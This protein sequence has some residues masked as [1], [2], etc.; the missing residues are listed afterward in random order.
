LAMGVQQA[1][2]DSPLFKGAAPSKP[3]GPPPADP[4]YLGVES[5]SVWTSALTVSNDTST[6]ITAL[7]SFPDAASDYGKGYTEANKFVAFNA[8][9]IGVFKAAP[10]LV[11]SYVST[12]NLVPVA[13]H[14][15]ADATADL[16]IGKTVTPGADAWAYY[17]ALNKGGDGWFNRND[18]GIT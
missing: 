10:G 2:F 6:N 15:A 11:N 16:R 18:A 4:A 13:Q 5:G 17:P 7:Y 9:E 8:T 12:L 3:S 1:Y 14:D